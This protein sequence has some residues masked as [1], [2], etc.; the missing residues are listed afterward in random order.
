MHGDQS[1]ENMY[2][3]QFQYLE[4]FSG[5]LVAVEKVNLSYFNQDQT[6]LVRQQG[7]LLQ[8]IYISSLLVLSLT[9]CIVRSWKQLLSIQNK[10]T[11]NL[12]F[13]F[14]VTHSLIISTVKKLST[15]N[16]KTY[17]FHV[18]VLTA[19][20]IAPDNYETAVKLCNL[21]LFLN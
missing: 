1:F 9:E 20:R 16:F 12:S 3:H 7:F 8:T 5:I 6:Y 17:K 14:T 10:K 11:V 15:I 4:T 2:F 21:N 13:P 18:L 19:L